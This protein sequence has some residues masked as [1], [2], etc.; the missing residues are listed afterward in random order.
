MKAKG[1]AYSKGLTMLLTAIALL[2]AMLP[3]KAQSAAAKDSVARGANAANTGD[4]VVQFMVFYPGS[5]IYE[6]E[7][8]A[9]LRVKTPKKDYAVNYGTFDFDAPNFV[10]RFVKGETDYMATSYPASLAQM[11]YAGAGRRITAHTI[12]LTPAQKERLIC[13]LDSNLQPENCVYRYNYVLDNCSTRPIAMLEKAL[14]DSIDFKPAKGIAGGE[15]TFRDMMKSYHRNYPWYQFG[16]DLALGSGIDYVLSEREKT[17]APAAADSMLMTATVNGL[18]LVTEYAVIND[19]PP[20]GAEEGP[21]TLMLTPLFVFWMLFIIVAFV[22]FR[23]IRCKKASKWLQSIFYLVLGVAGLVLTF[24][25]FISVH[26]ATS[27]NWL[28]IWI[29][30]LC[31]IPALL[32]WL[33][34]CNRLVFYYQIL[35]FA[36]VIVFILL[37]PILPQSFNAAMLPLA[38]S[39]A[40]LAATYIY[41]SNAQ[42]KKQKTNH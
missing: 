21:T 26:Y 38:L 18:P 13:L 30:P 14:G 20:F 10:Y 5:D 34:K 35:N 42:Y 16:I 32:I 37:W 15:V 3:A 31:L 12:N 7:G 27:P 28:Y 2:V 40:M 11:Y 9:A 33:K 29:N 23:D 19:V 41:T 4:T 36:A 17:F 25:I 22:C 24:L 1:T 8:H 6:L 39:D